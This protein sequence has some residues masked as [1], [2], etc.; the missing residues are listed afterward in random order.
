MHTKSIK[1]LITYFIPTLFL[2]SGCAASNS[3]RN[4]SKE[5]FPII[6]E[7]SKENGEVDPV[8]VNVTIDDDSIIVN[9]NFSDRVNSRVDT[10]KM[11]AIVATAVSSPPHWE[12]KLTVK[13]G[14][15]Q[16]M[17]TSINGDAGLDVVFTVDKPMWLYLSYWG[18]NHFQ[19]NISNR[20]LLS[21]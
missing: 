10:I 20:Q 16:I 12:F 14:T 3:D 7:F 15:H 1:Y 6:L 18:K 9:R 13:K 8:N 4:D 19:L 11:G 2:L 21:G 17:A 5:Q